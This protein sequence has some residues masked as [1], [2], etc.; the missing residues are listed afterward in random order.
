D[1]LLDDYTP[2]VLEGPTPDLDD[3]EVQVTGHYRN[4]RII[5]T[6]VQPSKR[7]KYRSGR[8]ART[9]A[10]L[11]FALLPFV[12]DATEHDEFM[13]ASTA[14]LRDE[15]TAVVS[16]QQFDPEATISIAVLPGAATA[17]SSVGVELDDARVAGIP[18]HQVLARVRLSGDGFELSEPARMVYAPS[19]TLPSTARAYYVLDSG[20][21][22]MLPNQSAT[23]GQLSVDLPHASSILFADLG[24]AEFAGNVDPPALGDVASV[25]DFGAAVETAEQA[26]QLGLDEF[27]E[28]IL[29]EALEDLAAEISSEL[30]AGENDGACPDNTRRLLQLAA[31]AM[32]VGNVDPALLDG[33]ERQARSCARSGTVQAQVRILMGGFCE[34]DETLPETRFL[35][36]EDGNIKGGGDYWLY[37]HDVDCPIYVG[38][39][40]RVE[41]TGEVGGYR[42]HM[43]LVAYTRGIVELPGPN[44]E[45]PT[46]AEWNEEEVTLTAQPLFP[47]F[48][49]G[50]SPDTRTLSFAI[51]PEDTL[52]Q[53]NASDGFVSVVTWTMQLGCD[54]RDPPQDSPTDCLYQVCYKG[55]VTD[56]PSEVMGVEEVPPQDSPNDCL[57]QVCHGGDIADVPAEY[58]NMT[59]V[60]LQVSPTDCERQFCNEGAIDWKDDFTEPGCT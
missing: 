32:Q 59:E 44:E 4:H 38:S 28:S 27:A 39:E 60:P 3:V 22:Q 15:S 48:T 43:D 45:N 41:L 11:L 13:L 53:M 14:I 26:Q 18:P 46:T 10:F 50:V 19:T 9:L 35:V 1:R 56:V 57:R 58:M 33:I 23:E 25:S 55:E 7:Y 21:L 34:F 40:G 8:Q 52:I 6:S 17:G 12:A 5:A 54:G 47:N 29:E 24:A 36:D 30:A 42:M 2:L 31:L 49:T 16:V 37:L 51:A 20:R